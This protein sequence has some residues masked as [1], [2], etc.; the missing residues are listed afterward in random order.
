AVR[1]GDEVAFQIKVANTGSGPAQKLV[2]QAKLSDG[3]HHPQG[4]VIE[5]ELT[6][7]APG[8]A[9][10]VTLRA[11]A[12]K[13]GPQSCTIAAAADGNPPESAK[14][15]LSVVEPRLEA[16]LAGPSRCVVRSEPTFSLEMANPGTA[17]TDP[18]QAWA[19]VPDGFEFLSATDGGAY[20][21]ANR[22]VCWKLS[23]LP[24]GTSTMVSF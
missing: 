10:T 15:A 7:L 3:L 18:V 21:P 14:S 23:G 6:N 1:V 4:G 9:K 5:A 24:A 17:G 13:A 8:E 11:M 2:I 20:T 12:T 19:V 22:T 16:K